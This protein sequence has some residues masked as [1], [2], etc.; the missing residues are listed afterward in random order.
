[1]SDRRVKASIL[2]DPET[3]AAAKQVAARMGL[4]FA[5]YVASRV[6]ADVQRNTQA[7]EL[8]ALKSAVGGAI[9]DLDARMSDA[10]DQLSQRIADATE[11]ALNEQRERTTAD[12]HAINKSLFHV[13]QTA[14]AGKATSHAADAHHAPGGKE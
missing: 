4:T 3:H 6:L 11:R 13:V 1:M 9:A 8:D 10:F 5:D 2:M 12:L 7:A 14:L